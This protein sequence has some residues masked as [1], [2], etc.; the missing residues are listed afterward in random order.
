MTRDFACCRASEGSEGIWTMCFG[1]S[2]AL[3]GDGAR[4]DLKGPQFEG[5]LSDDFL[6]FSGKDF[7]L[8]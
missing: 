8:I 4:V 5:E 6:N 3:V 1:E 7:K 2:R